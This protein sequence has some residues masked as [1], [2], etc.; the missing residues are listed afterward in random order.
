MQLVVTWSTVISPMTLWPWFFRKALTSSW[1][2]GI[3]SVMTLRR[4]V[5]SDDENRAG[6]EFSW[7]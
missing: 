2:S 6:I 4:S 1:K 7:A 3:F 5:V